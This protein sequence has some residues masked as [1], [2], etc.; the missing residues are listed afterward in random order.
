VTKPI[1][2]FAHVVVADFEFIAG[3]GRHPDVVC[4][5]F[6]VDGAPTLVHWRD[7]NGVW[8]DEEG[9]VLSDEPPY[10]T[11]DDTLFVCFTQAELTCHL[12]LSWP[13][14]VHVL[15]LNCELRRLT[16]GL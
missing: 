10:P 2:D 4:L 9:N 13:L 3:N 1:S 14:P 6:R 5:G 11:G 16:A 7:D 12:A 8:I 15:D